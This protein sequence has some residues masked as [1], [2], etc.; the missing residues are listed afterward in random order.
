M[1]P[2]SIVIPTIGRPSLRALLDSLDR[3]EGPLPERIVVVDDRRG[4]HS[5]TQIDGFT[6]AD[7]LVVLRSRGI[8]PA[9][10]RNIGW[11]ATQTPWVVF[12][13]DDV[14]V[15]PSWRRDLQNDLQDA[16]ERDA[17]VSA[18]VDV[19]LPRDRRPTDWERNVASLSSAMW[20]TADMAYR[21]DALEA[22]G[23][24]DD[25]FP[26]AY[27]EDADIALRVQEAGFRLRSGTRRSI[28]PVRPADPWVSVRLQRGN[29]DDAL[30]RALHGKDWRER[31][32]CPPGRF[33]AHV[34]TVT[35]AAIA[36]AATLAW[37]CLTAEF[38]WRRIA[39]GPKTPAEIAAMSATSAVIPFAAVYHR[40]RG[41]L[42]ARRLT[43]RA[44]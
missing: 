31:A 15:T 12:L 16:G 21:R 19:P 17:A 44:S 18:R 26:R 6:S 3:S 23:G 35:A 10:A 32:Q 2:Y 4:E 7:R 27:R 28:H 25:R 34:T 37:A 9:G 29:A 5:L 13:D 39:P 33:R 14:L 41:E 24:F 20:I 8:G 36:A 38:A 30:M 22:V 40:L 1:T 43:E 42:R 11:H